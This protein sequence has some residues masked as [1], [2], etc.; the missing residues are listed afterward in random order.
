MKYKILIVLF[1]LSLVSSM[2]L[3]LKSIAEICGVGSGCEIIHYS[4]YNS[5]FGVDNSD[6]G[7][8]IF[9]FLIL[10]TISQMIK[11]T[12]NKKLLLYSSIIIG[13]G[14]ALFFLY[15]QQFV[16][17]AYCKYCLIVDFSLILS[18]LVILPEINKDFPKVL[19]KFLHTQQ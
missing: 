2:S 12:K 9:A 13:S 7:I 19:N 10:L 16:L 8:F 6:Y 11:P 1:I 5:T 14:I 17:S 18:L 15:I 3:S 4:G